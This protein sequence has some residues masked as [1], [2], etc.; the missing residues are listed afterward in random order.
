[1]KTKTDSL[2]FVLPSDIWCKINKLL[3]YYE[4]QLTKCCLERRLEGFKISSRF[5][6]TMMLV[7]YRIA[8]KC[9]DFHHCFRWLHY[10]YSRDCHLR[11]YFDETVFNSDDLILKVL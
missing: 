3:K 5:L 11:F 2:F 6:K 1:M 7:E 9:H 8:K 10:H 4:Y